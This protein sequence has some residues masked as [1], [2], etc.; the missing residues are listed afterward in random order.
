M[1]KGGFLPSSLRVQVPPP[2]RQRSGRDTVP[3]YSL[4]QLKATDLTVAASRCAED[5]IL[6]DPLEPFPPSQVEGERLESLH[7]LSCPRLRK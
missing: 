1:G 4:L 5:S 7:P 3:R 2:A 6:R